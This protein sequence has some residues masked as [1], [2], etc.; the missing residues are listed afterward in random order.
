MLSLIA[1]FLLLFRYKMVIFDDVMVIHEWKVFA[2]LPTA[3]E[4]KDITNIE[5]KSKHHIIIEHPKKS[6]IYV[7]N[8]QAFMDAYNELKSNKD[9]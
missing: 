3:I 5:M 4:Y 7:F 9:S 8:A 2:M 6:H 1:L